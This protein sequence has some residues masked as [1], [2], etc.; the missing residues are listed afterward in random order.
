MLS[1][2]ITINPNT[3]L[4]TVASTL[5]DG[6]YKL[7]VEVTNDCGIIG[8]QCYLIEVQPD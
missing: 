8:S 6:T 2:A 3:G 4:I 1:G 5:A 7:T